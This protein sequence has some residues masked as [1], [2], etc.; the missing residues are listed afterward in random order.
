MNDA[1]VN[2]LRTI[3]KEEINATLE[4]IV[5]KL[6][7]IEQQL[8]DPKTGLKRLSEKLDALWEQTVKLTESSE[9]VKDV[10]KSQ[11]DVLNQSNDNIQ[12]LDKRMVVTEARLGI[13]SPPELTVIQ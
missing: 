2:K 5:D 9:Q 10:I 7:D 1:D 13:V 11:T 8:N 4:P 6:G 12:K 3:I